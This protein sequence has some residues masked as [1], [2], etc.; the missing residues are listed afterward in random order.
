MDFSQ[1]A[2]VILNYNGQFFLEKFLPSVTAHSQGAR[3]IVADNCSTDRSLAFLKENY[4]A[5]EVIVNAENG[6]FAKGY[7][8]ALKQVDSKYYLLLNSDVEVTDNWLS[9]LYEAI[10]SDDAVAG[11]QPKVLAYNNP[12]HFEHAGACG[13]YLDHNFYPF[14]RGR[15]FDHTEVDE[16]QYQGMAEV[17]WT[18]GACM[19]IRSELFHKAGGFDEDFFAHMEE[20]D[21]CWRIKR[22]GYT[23]KVVPASEVYHVG[24]GT[25]SYFSPVKTY[26]NFRNSLFMITK[27]YEKNLFP[28][29]LYRMILDGVAGM[30]FLVTFKPRHFAAVLKAHFHFYGKLRIMLEK[31]RNIQRS[32]NHF[33]DAGVY[34]GSILWA[35]YF[36]KIKDFSKLNLRFFRT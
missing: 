8:D 33:N 24:G 19:L 4:P 2:I 28:K 16:N 21:L 7:N 30:M 23:F 6:G 18:S 32:E 9:P 27:N 5:V 11:V 1:I 22:Y 3:I 36:K 12:H 34:Y 25:L 14:C 29:M 17:F 15:I 31:R 20:I 13:G 26:L 10:L 35:R